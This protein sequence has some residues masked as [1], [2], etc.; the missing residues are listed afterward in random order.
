MNFF[1]VVDMSVCHVTTAQTYDGPKAVPNG[2]CDPH[3]GT[4]E[5]DLKCITCGGTT[6]ECPGHFGHIELEKPVYNVGFLDKTLHVLRSVCFYCSKLKVPIEDERMQRLLKEKNNAKRFS[7]VTRLCAKVLTCEGTEDEGNVNDGS[8]IQASVFL[9]QG[10]GRKQPKFRRNQDDGHYLEILGEFPAAEGARE[11][12]R[13]ISAEQAL[14]IF[15]N[16]STEDAIALGFD[17][18]YAMPQWMITTVLPVPPLAVRPLVE[19]G[20]GGAKSHDDV[21][22]Q[23]CSY[24]MLFR[25]LPNLSAA[26]KW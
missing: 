2:L 15:K 12:K 20:T 13:P 24:V 22:F 25:T 18:M 16:I 23:V 14:E 6:G 26:L 9:K 4:M 11:S 5:R 7:H 3:M 21:T 8:A 19:M 17:P 1:T 10:C